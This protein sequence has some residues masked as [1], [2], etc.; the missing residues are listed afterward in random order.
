MIRHDHV[1]THCNLEVAL[2]F[3]RKENERRMNL[4]ESQAWY[5]LMRTKRDEIKRLV[6]KTRVRRNGRRSNSC[7]TLKPVATALWAVEFFD[8]VSI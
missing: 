2:G 4:I 3:P 7:F 1:A 6:S 8:F 5:S